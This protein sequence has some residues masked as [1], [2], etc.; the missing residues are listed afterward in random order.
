MK[1]KG[2]SE[3]GIR[4]AT[5]LVIIALFIIGY[6]LLISD[7]AREDLGVEL[8]SSSSGDD[9]YD[10]EESRRG[11]TLL[12]TSPGEV[13][14]YEKDEFDI[15]LGTIK[16]YSDVGSDIEVLSDNLVVSKTLFK[17][18]TRNLNFN[19]NDLAD[20]KNLNLFFFVRK[21]DGNLFVE[22]NGHEIFEG[23][24]G[25]NDVPIDLPLNYVEERNTLKIGMSGL[26]LFGSSA[27]LG[28]VYIKKSYDKERKRDTATFQLSSTDKSGLKDSELEYFA[29]CLDDED[30]ILTITLNERILSKR[31]IICNTRPRTIELNDV[32]LRKGV[33]VLVFEIDRGGYELEDVK[34]AVTTSEKRYPEY[35]FDVD[36]DLYEDVKDC[37]D[38]ECLDD[39]KDDCRDDC[40]DYRDYSDCLDDCYNDCDDECEDLTCITGLI[41]EFTFENDDERKEAT[42]T[43]NKKMFTIDTTRGTY[44]KDVSEYIN[45]GANYIKIIPKV[46]F[47][48]EALEVYEA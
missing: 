22:F 33:N 36:D 5:F 35:N 29:N 45:R 40:R 41:L 44:V 11:I 27:S 14:P 32:D 10:N 15:N 34:V 17:S 12:S 31:Q 25:A 20:L 46:A 39:C 37:E 26:G 18:T 9:Y 23:E 43:V 2:Q 13:S 1:K 24:V 8:D 48:I 7:E 28:S 3:E 6:V 21:S 4:V 16:L 38:A 19:I 47:D 42:V 30:G